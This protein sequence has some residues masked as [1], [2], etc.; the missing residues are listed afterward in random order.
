MKYFEIIIKCISYL[1][2]ATAS[3]CNIGT[4]EKICNFIEN[5]FLCFLPEKV[6]IMLINNHYTLGYLN[7]II[8]KNKALN[9]KDENEEIYGLIKEAIRVDNNCQIVSESSFLSNLKCCDQIDKSVEEGNVI[10]LFIQ[11]VFN[12]LDVLSYNDYE[13]GKEGLI[14]CAKWNH[15]PSM[16]IL[17]YIYVLEENY[18]EGL[19]WL[20]IVTTLDKKI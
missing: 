11:S 9:T 15:Y 10:G 1:N 19:Y 17:S 14:R 20:N 13:T 18:T 3:N 5:A 6:S 7:H 12:I 16:I 4:R 2:Y 8:R